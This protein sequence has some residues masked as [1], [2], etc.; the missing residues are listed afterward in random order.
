MQETTVKTYGSESEFKR[1]AGRMAKKG[2]RVQ[3]V[4]R[5]QRLPGCARGCLLGLFSFLIRP[6]DVLLVTYVKGN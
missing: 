6:S 2:W 1:D 5:E 3:N 4:A